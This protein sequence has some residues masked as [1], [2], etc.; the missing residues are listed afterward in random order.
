MLGNE[1]FDKLEQLA[2][3]SCKGPGVT[4]LSLSPQHRQSLAV[5]EEWMQAA[6]LETCRDDIGNLIGSYQVSPQKKT[7]MLGSHQDTVVMGGKYDG[8]LGVVLP[9]V[10][11]GH[12]IAR[13][14]LDCNLKIVAFTDEE[15]I[16]FQTTYLG[17]MALNGHLD[18]ALMERT[19]KN[20]TSLRQ[21]ILD[22]G[23]DPENVLRA[24]PSQNPDAYLEIHIEQ[25][26]VLEDA[27]LPVGVVTSIQSSYRYEVT[28]HGLAGHAGTVPMHLRRDPMIS[29]AKIIS[30]LPDL[31]QEYAPLV[32]TVGEF[33][34][35]PGSVN[36]IP[37]QVRFTIDIRSPEE[38]NILRAMEQAERILREVCAQNQTEYCL[39]RYNAIP[40]TACDPSLVAQVERA[41][42][43]SGIPVFDMASGAGHD[44]Q[45]MSSVCPVG[46][47]F[48]RCKAGVSHSPYEEVS[49]QDIEHAAQAVLHFIKSF[50]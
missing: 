47:L 3:Y 25:G 40:A 8:A 13:G 7:L 45:E 26:P 50:Q 5:L 21:A 27:G 37:S 24:R 4:R 33:H 49:A 18:R 10:C 38:K 12:L 43:Q 39:V 14:E 23:G 16:R 2:T 6:G 19:D 30:R 46:M 15:G 34:V 31:S 36:V 28:I 1:I 41:V 32:L 42:A 44:A 17:S 11:A 20:G 22:F 29:A 35:T 9:I 48:V